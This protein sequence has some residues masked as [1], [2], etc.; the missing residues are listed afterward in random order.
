MATTLSWADLPGRRVA[1]WGIGVEGKASLARLRAMNHG[2]VVLVDAK[3]SNLADGTEVLGV[4]DG[5]AAALRASDIVIKTPGISRYDDLVA[6]LLGAGVEIV[7]GLGLWLAGTDAN[8]VIAVTGTKGKSTTTSIAGGLIAG[9]GHSVVI[10]GNLGVAPWDPAIPSASDWWVVE[11]SSYQACDIQVGPAVVGVTSLSQD[12]LGWHRGV[13][14]YYRDKL[15]L[16]TRPRVRCV[17][18]EGHDPLL[19]EYAGLLG[20]SVDWV[21]AEPGE[22]A[23][24]L[25]VIGAHNR[26]NAAVALELLRA[27]G[28]PGV[29]DE[30]AL[31]EAAAAYEPLPSRLTILGEVAGVGFVDDSLSTNVLPTLA[32][33]EAFP[34][35]R[36]ALIVGGQERGIDYQPLA[37]GL[38][39]RQDDVKVFTVPDNGE[40]IGVVIRAVVGTPQVVDCED[41]R[42]ATREGFR[43]VGGGG[44]VLLSPA[45]PSFGRFAD[46]RGRAAAFVTAMDELR[47]GDG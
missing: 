32:A 22:W 46:Y 17:V 3:P 43:W 36:V 10:G 35:R 21:D 34:C 28:V 47:S 2:D 23:D 8:R 1:V 16:C 29:T 39:R 11:V 6:E 18:A 42:A 31:A 38:R 41:I 9:L 44:V 20:P 26:R 37:E 24:R 7:G 19:R 25:N 4:D 5:G 27:A 15:S 14:N 13:E 40:R 12:H 33:V 45:A 30:S